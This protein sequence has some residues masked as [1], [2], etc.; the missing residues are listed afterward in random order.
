[1]HKDYF[2]KPGWKNFLLSILIWYTGISVYMILS[3]HSEYSITYRYI[4]YTKYAWPSFLLCY[5][6]V[7]W[8]LPK[9]LLT[10]RFGLLIFLN[11][12]ALAAY[13]VIRYYNNSFLDQY[14]YFVYKNNS[15]HPGNLSDIIATEIRLGLIFTFI[16]YTY[17]FIF[18]WVIIEQVKRKLENEK[19]KADLALLR[20]QLNPHFLFNTINDI[21]YLA[22]IK[23]DK[24][25][26]ALLKLSELLRYV[27]HEKEEWVPLEKE[28]THLKQFVELQH[29]RFPHDVVK[30]NIENGASLSSYQI[31]PLLFTTFV[32]NAFKHGEPGTEEK[33][34]LIS[35]NIHDKM[36]SYK[37]SN[38]IGTAAS[39]DK[40]SGI[41]K[42]NLEKRLNLLYPGKHKISFNQE[43]GSYIAHL[44]LQLN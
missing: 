39:K 36:L 27:L 28:I 23:S 5:A 17:R 35:I 43:N 9:Y 2:V 8:V 44:E 11:L 20:Y 13:I 42:S 10:K 30:L 22:I 18:D 1:M 34:V 3:G 25:P 26:D 16:S 32:E 33:P 15:Y 14:A 38:S 19:L 29:F 4:F 7:M 31:P 6:I 41:G 12:L 21:Y 37:V 40:S 24:T